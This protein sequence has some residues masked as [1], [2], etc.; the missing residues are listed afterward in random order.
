MPPATVVSEMIGM[1]AVAPDFLTLGMSSAA[2]LA[3]E[4]HW[5]PPEPEG[6]GSAEDGKDSS[7]QLPDSVDD[8]SE[9]IANRSFTERVVCINRR[10]CDQK[11]LPRRLL[12]CRERM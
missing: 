7:E 12:R 1:L 10:K 4:R 8:P 9:E 6:N 5:T 3:S 11:V 2:K